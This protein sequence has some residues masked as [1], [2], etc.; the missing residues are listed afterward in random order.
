[1][2]FNTARAGPLAEVPGWFSEIPNSHLHPVS[3][4]ENRGNCT[5]TWNSPSWLCFC[6]ASSSL[7]KR[8]SEGTGVHSGAS[9][10]LVSSTC[11]PSWTTPRQPPVALSL[12]SHRLLRSPAWK[13]PSS[14]CQ[15]YSVHV[16]YSR[17][18]GWWAIIFPLLKGIL[19]EMLQRLLYKLYT[20]QLAYLAFPQPSPP[21]LSPLYCECFSA[22]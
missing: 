8:S 2:N 11:V 22:G 13:V 5:K 21:I 16:L 17:T 7:W 9:Q 18:N 12:S 14:V 10:P 20:P 4:A 6:E 1:M 19:T 15:G 3:S